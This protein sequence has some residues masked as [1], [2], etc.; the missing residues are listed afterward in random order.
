MYNYFEKKL[1]KNSGYFIAVYLI[2]VVSL[3]PLKVFGIFHGSWSE[4]LFNVIPL[5]VFIPL[6]IYLGFALCLLV[7]RYF[8][9]LF[10]KG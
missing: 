5:L 6:A 7:L 1:D 8:L 10:N 9:D 2:F 3:F 4:L